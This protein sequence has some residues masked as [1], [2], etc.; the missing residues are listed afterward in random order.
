MA[1][2][3]GQLQV[4]SLQTQSL[5][6]AESCSAQR[7]ASISKSLCAHFHHLF[8]WYSHI[9]AGNLPVDYWIAKI[10]AQ[11]EAKESWFAA[12][13][14]RYQSQ[15]GV[16]LIP[17][18]RTYFFR[19]REKMWIMSMRNEISSWSNRK[20]LFRVQSCKRLRDT[21]YLKADSL[22]RI[23]I[24]IRCNLCLQTSDLLFV[25]DLFQNLPECLEGLHQS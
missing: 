4:K 17:A 25:V 8:D 24:L 18:S 16:S 5:T 2:L 20:I 22:Y 21:L 6:H 15:L 12:I 19:N 11:Q 1:V 14:V 23:R 10:T 3:G 13:V 7:S 9:R